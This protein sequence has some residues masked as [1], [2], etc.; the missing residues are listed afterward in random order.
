MKVGIHWGASLYMGQL[1]PGGRLDVTA[2]GDE[3]NE[4]ARIQDSAEEGRTLVSKQLVE[5]LTDD[6]AASLGLD[7]EKLSYQT[8][9]ELERATEK[10]VRDAGTIPVTP[11]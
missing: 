5:H 4:T 6:D 2:L 7:I 11:L 3:V 9:S 1:V 8:V 10:A